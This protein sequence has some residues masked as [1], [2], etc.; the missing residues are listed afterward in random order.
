MSG[1]QIFFIVFLILLLIRQI[2]L[3]RI[4]QKA[5]EDGWKAFVPVVYTLV[6]LKLIGKPNW[7][8]IW[9]FI[10]GINILMSI[11]ISVDLAKTFGRFSLADHA[12]A[13]ILPFAYFPY[14]G[15]NPDLK[16]VGPDAAKAHHRSK[17]R[18]WIDA[19]AFAIIAATVIRSF[20][21]EAYTIPT[22]S[23]E[24]TLLVDDFLF[25]SKMNYGARVPMTPLSFPLAHNQMPVFGGKSYF[26]WP[27]IPYYRLPGW[28]K[29]ERNDIVVFNWPADEGRPVDKKD[30]YIKR[31]VAIGG[32]SLTIKDRQIF[33]NNKAEPLPESAQFLFKVGTDGNFFNPEALKKLGVKRDEMQLLGID[34]KTEHTIYQAWLTNKAAEGIKAMNNVKELEPFIVPKNTFSGDMFPKTGRLTW[35]IDNF[36]PLYIPKKGDVIPMTVNNYYI[37]QKAIREY[38]NNPTLEMRDTLVYMNGQPLK[39]YAFKMNYYFMM[40]DNRHNSLDSRMWGFVPEDHVVG[41]PIIIWLSLDRENSF[42]NMIRWKRMFKLI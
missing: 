14:L 30:N 29:V 16:Y 40:G 25:V 34:P 5:G 32:D 36:G 13:A 9:F 19:I 4:F 10:P 24:E 21:I 7:W 18:E 11:I 12:A 1:E 28:E 26:E 6:W 39:E 2:G 27:K 37:Y 38:E 8:L 17:T 33:I 35:N 3:Y 23:M 41:K 20:F 22:P 31:C 42:F 15:F